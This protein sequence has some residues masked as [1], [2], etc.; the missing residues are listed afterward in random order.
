[1]END[2]ELTKIDILFDQLSRFQKQISRILPK[3]EKRVSQQLP[4]VKPV[5]PKITALL[6]VAVA[7]ITFVFIVLEFFIFDI[8]SRTLTGDMLALNITLVSVFG[9]LFLFYIVFDRFPVFVNILV[10]LQTSILVALMV[11]NPGSST[12]FMVLGFPLSAMAAFFLPTGN[13]AFWLVLFFVIGEVNVTYLFG[14]EETLSYATSAG[15]FAA[16]G[17]VGAL[18]R[19][20]NEAYYSIEALYD[21]LHGTHMQLT[22]YSEGVRQLAV[23]EERNRVAREM[24]DSLGHSLTVAVVQLEGAGRLIPKDPDRA[25]GIISNMREQLK[26]ALTELRTTLAQLRS[27]DPD[28]VVGNLA[29]AL[30]ELK[31]NF[32]Q[33]TALEIQLDLPD[34]LPSLD[35]EQ[36]LAIFRA[37]QEGLTNV[38][39]HAEANK[40]WITLDPNEAG[41]TLTV[42]DNGKGFP[43]EIADGRFGIRGMQERAE[44]FGGSLKRKNRPDGGG[45][46]IFT[47]PFEIPVRDE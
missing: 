45:E 36:R 19:R 39:R 11:L 20:S 22:R 35:T 8:P 5:H 4:I 38:Q 14:F 15:A 26:N 32:M 13:A 34:H 28:E 40:V 25:V 9:S 41:I 43:K 12:D 24:H 6:F 29:M 7:L 33:A 16:F 2:S 18:V 27:D 21:E 1:M 23:S 47:I 3:K 42:A 17:V 31:L 46:L 44:F 30:T 10:F 37:A